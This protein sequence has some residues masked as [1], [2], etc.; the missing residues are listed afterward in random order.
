MGSLLCTWAWTLPLRRGVLSYKKNAC[1]VCVWLY[2]Y[3]LFW[4]VQ[5]VVRAFDLLSYVLLKDLIYV[6]LIS[7]HPPVVCRQSF[8][9]PEGSIYTRGYLLA[10]NG[11]RGKSRQQRGVE[12][13]VVA[14]CKKDIEGWGRGQAS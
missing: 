5:S 8:P 1:V 2:L 13:V 7:F 10:T 12:M 9:Y 11:T 4:C 6:Y 3:I 14:L